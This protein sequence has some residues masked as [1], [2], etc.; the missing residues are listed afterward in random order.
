MFFPKRVAGGASGAIHLRGVVDI[1]SGIYSGY[2]LTAAGKVYS[3][4]YNGHGELGNGSTSNS[5]MPVLVNFSALDLDPGYSFSSIGSGNHHGIAIGVDGAIYAWG[6]NGYG[7]GN[8]GDGTKVN[9]ATPVRVKGGE[10][11][12]EYLKDMM[13]AVGGTT[14]SIGA[15]K[16]GS[17]WTWG[18]N[19]Y[20]QLGD[21]TC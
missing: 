15:K 10:S 12:D 20:G 18:D 7:N 6:Y 16:D 21:R 4:G 19:G 14:H 1:S 13:A 5:N 9:R 3:W 11:G 17:V 2:A 8:I